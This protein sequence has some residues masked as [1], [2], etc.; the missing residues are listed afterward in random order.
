MLPSRFCGEVG[1]SGIEAGY[2]QSVEAL[3]SNIGKILIM[4]VD[5]SASLSFALN[6]SNAKWVDVELHHLIAMPDEA[7]KL[8]LSGLQRGIGHHIQ[9]ADMQSADI[10]RACALRLYYELAL[11]LQAF[12]ARQ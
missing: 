11:I 3:S 9:E 8:A 7:H 2:Y 6:S 4:L 1:T 10:L 5:V 12:E